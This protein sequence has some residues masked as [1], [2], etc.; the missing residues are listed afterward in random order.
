M[1]LPIFPLHILQPT[2]RTVPITAS[3]HVR[4]A[5]WVEY[6]E[7]KN[8]QLRAAQARRADWIYKLRAHDD[9]SW[10]PELEQHSRKVCLTEWGWET[11]IQSDAGWR[12]REKGQAECE[13]DEQMNMKPTICSW[14]PA[15]F[16]WA[17][18]RVPFSVPRREASY[19]VRAYASHPGHI[20]LL[21]GLPQR[22]QGHIRGDR[23]P[24]KW[25]K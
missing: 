25:E 17:W 14:T 6:M 19:A 16:A 8:K 1:E 11:V 21:Q 24:P 4:L 10:I 5:Q 23:F 13:T 2:G 7:G 12:E 9:Y 15:W 22:N 3:R 20:V 18:R